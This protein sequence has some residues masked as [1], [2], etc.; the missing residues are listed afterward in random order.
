MN[1]TNLTD[2]SDVDCRLFLC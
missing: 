1:N 2:L